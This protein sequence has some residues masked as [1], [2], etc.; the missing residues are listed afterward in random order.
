MEFLKLSRQALLILDSR[1][2]ILFLI[3]LFLFISLFEVAGVASI[4]WFLVFVTDPL[5]HEYKVFNFAAS[6]LNTNNIKV[7]VP[8]IGVTILMF[9]LLKS[10]LSILTNKFI[11][12]YSFNQGAL[13]RE[14][15]LKRYFELPYE[16]YLSK[17]MSD[18]VQSILNLP[19][20]YS[21]NILLSIIRIMSEGVVCIAIFGFILYYDYFAFLLISSIL[22]F[23]YYSYSK[24][25]KK[26]SIL[27]GEK[28][29]IESKNIITIITE[30]IAGFVDIKLKRVEDFF[31]KRLSNS[32]FKFSHAAAKFEIINTIPRYLIE[33]SILT[34]LIIYLVIILFIQTDETNILGTLG[35]LGAAAMRV[36]PSVN[37]ILSSVNQT[38]YGKDTINILSSI[39][40]NEEKHVLYKHCLTKGDDR[41]K[42][43]EIS[44][45]NFSYASDASKNIVSEASLVFKHGKI[46]GIKGKSGSGKSTLLSL[47]LG[48]LKPLS[49][50]IIYHYQAI[51]YDSSECIPSVS[52]ISQTPF[53]I[54][55]SIDNNVALGINQSDISTDKIKA[56]LK[57]AKLDNHVLN[58]G[59]KTIGDRGS[60]LSGGQRQRL[61]IA[62]ALYN[63][64]QLIIFD[65]PT[66][67]L[68]SKTRDYIVSEI[69]SL[70]KDAI[71]IVVSHDEAVL[72]LCDVIYEIDD[73]Y[74]NKII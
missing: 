67:A 26:K 46:S 45:L 2:K 70:K 16:E 21:Q 25:Y 4:A 6:L 1:D 14:R 5:L 48:L 44:N 73:G 7:V 37:L 28:S 34:F 9:L 32:A 61:I 33:F 30:S 11:Y 64:S 22:F 72:S 10:T 18:Y 15:L 55:D 74:I 27:Y 24:I 56:A 50:Q 49:G 43:I 39:L 41:L 54:N 69:N 38:R 13:L 47:I 29:N 20:Q 71:I 23:V 36:A 66:S 31:L 65:E 17:P 42:S 53:L 51:S 3:V 12:T 8:T 40:S 63:S 59:L 62:R 58:S 60:V 68:D 35:V 19:V 52:Y 57:I